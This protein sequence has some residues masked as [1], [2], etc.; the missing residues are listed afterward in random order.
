MIRTMRNSSDTLMT[1]L[2]GIHVR[3]R[4]YSFGNQ[5]NM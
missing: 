3:L 4:Q 5:N 2:M 1:I